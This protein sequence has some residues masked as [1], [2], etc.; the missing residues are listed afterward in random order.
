MDSNNGFILTYLIKGILEISGNA[1][2]CKM[3]YKN[4]YFHVF[5][6]QT[7]VASGHTLAISQM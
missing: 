2:L 4:D 5:D 7:R 6:V 1:L 3:S